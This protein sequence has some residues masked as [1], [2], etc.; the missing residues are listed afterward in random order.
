MTLFHVF[1]C[2]LYKSGKHGTH[3]NIC[4]PY[5]HAKVITSVESEAV[6]F[7]MQF[8]RRVL[9]VQTSDH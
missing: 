9:L 7:L 6:D 5:Q 1:L 8:T 3:G 4:P 2:V